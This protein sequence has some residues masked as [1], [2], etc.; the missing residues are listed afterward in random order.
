MRIHGNRV[1]QAKRG[2][3]GLSF[4]YLNGYNM[5]KTRLCRVSHSLTE[6]RLARQGMR[7]QAG[8]MAWLPPALAQR[9]A[10]EPGDD[11][12]HIHGG[13][14]QELLEVCAREAT[15]PTLAQIEAS[16]ALREA[17]LHARPQ[18]IL[19]GEFRCL[20]AL[21]RRLERLVVGLQPDGEL[22][23]GIFGLG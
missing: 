4:H 9:L 14:R 17:T 13:C 1:R 11:A 21:P 15:V 6:Y 10:P 12:D 19:C 23:R 3:Q 5:A 18:G 20:L 7:R 8:E 22:A 2:S 16:Y